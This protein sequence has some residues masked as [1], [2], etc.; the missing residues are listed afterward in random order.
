[1][2]VPAGELAILHDIVPLQDIVGKTGDAAQ[3]QPGGK[4]LNDPRV[5][6]RIKQRVGY[7]AVV[8]AAANNVREFGRAAAMISQPN[9][10]PPGIVEYQLR[11][12]S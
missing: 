6:G 3:G 11:S 4:L 1:M 12:T 8:D 5:V 2:S 7:V 10:K 9:Q